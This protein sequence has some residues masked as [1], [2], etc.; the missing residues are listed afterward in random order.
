MKRT[1]ILSIVTILVLLVFITAPGCQEEEKTPETQPSESEAA[2]EPETAPEP[3]PPPKEIEM[4]ITTAAFE[5]GET[6]PTQYGCNGQNISPA[7]S[8]SG[9]P[10]GTQSFALIV[11]DPDAPAGTF[12]HWVIFNIPGSAS[13]LEEAI[14]ANP[15]LTNGALQG[16]N[17][18]DKIGYGGP[19]PPEG[20]KHRYYFVL[21]ALDQTLD[22]DAG[23]S[24][25]QV[26]DAMQGHI[27]AQAELMGTYQR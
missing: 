14:P 27:L 1:I 6:M 9:V 4:A 19:C 15:Q 2:S 13:E 18:Y 21:Y 22:L 16:K 20:T 25:A 26:L 23:A 3:E 12:T 10:E 8:W 7:L 17:N 5:Y 11:D 24:K